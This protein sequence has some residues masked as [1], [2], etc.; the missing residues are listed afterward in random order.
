MRSTPAVRSR[1]ESS[2]WATSC[3]TPTSTATSSVAGRPLEIRVGNQVL[4]WGESLFYQGGVSAINTVDLNRLRAPGS[5]LKEAFLPAP[6]VRVSAEI[7]QNFSVEAFYQLYWNYTQLDPVGSYFSS[8]DMVGSGAEG[9]MSL[10][11]PGIEDGNFIHVARQLA[12]E[13]E[14]TWV[15]KEVMQAA[16]VT[17]DLPPEALVEAPHL[18]FTDADGQVVQAKPGDFP[19][20]A[21]EMAASQVQRYCALQV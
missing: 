8:N 15:D 18:I 17:G 1:A 16:L 10:Y 5:E 3:W 13:P 2:A 20:S 6:M 19:R 7:F 14:P 11:D 21:E 4:S 12:Q 9:L